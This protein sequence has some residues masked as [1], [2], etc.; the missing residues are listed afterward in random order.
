MILHYWIFWYFDDTAFVKELDLHCCVQVF[1]VMTELKILTFDILNF[2]S[3]IV[4]SSSVITKG[5]SLYDFL[6]VTV[7]KKFTIS[8]APLLRNG[9]L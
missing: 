6:R 3:F 2:V 9:S 1:V 7:P 4:M 8:R 5:L